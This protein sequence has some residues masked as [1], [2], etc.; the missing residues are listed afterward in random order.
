MRVKLISEGKEVDKRYLGVRL[1]WRSDGVIYETNASQVITKF[2]QGF[3]FPKS[4][5]KGKPEDVVAF[6]INDKEIFRL[7]IEKFSK[8]TN[9]RSFYISSNEPGLEEYLEMNGKKMNYIK[10]GFKFYGF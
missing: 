7:K 4:T 10:K 1:L 9:V 2:E 3:L 6:Q 5:F 8:S